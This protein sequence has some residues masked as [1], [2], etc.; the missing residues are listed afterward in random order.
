[1]PL[2]SSRDGLR[3]QSFSTALEALLPLHFTKESTETQRM[4]RPRGD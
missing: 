2:Q 1:M 4:R 3:G